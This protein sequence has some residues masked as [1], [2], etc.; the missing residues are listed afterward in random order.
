MVA[1]KVVVVALILEPHKLERTP[2]PVR[3][4]QPSELALEPVKRPKFGVPAGLIRISRLPRPATIFIEPACVAI[5]M[6][7]HEVAA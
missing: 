3:A 5:G 6:A 2:A 7:D 1:M 4:I